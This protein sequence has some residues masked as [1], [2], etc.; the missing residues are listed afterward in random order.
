[1]SRPRRVANFVEENP[2]IIHL[3]SESLAHKQG[4]L[5]EIEESFAKYKALM[6]EK[7]ICFEKLL[8]TKDSLLNQ[9]NLPNLS[10]T[11]IVLRQKHE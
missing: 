11:Y 10:L 8:T 2:Q 5:C 3:L 7:C 4:L 6:N 1:M 9:R